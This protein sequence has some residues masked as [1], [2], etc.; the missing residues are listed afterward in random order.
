M[1]CVTVWQFHG[2]FSSVVP[3]PEPTGEPIDLANYGEQK[4]SI[5]QHFPY[6]K[7]NTTVAISSLLEA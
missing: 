1:A 5:A 4:Q 3:D 2:R 6:R 7:E